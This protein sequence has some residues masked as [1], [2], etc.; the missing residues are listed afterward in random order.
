MGVVAVLWVEEGGEVDF[1]VV[2][3]GWFLKGRVAGCRDEEAW[4]VVA[5]VWVRTFSLLL[6]SLPL[7]QKFFPKSHFSFYRSLFI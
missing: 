4:V 6:I 2:V 5:A 3:V 1:R 7:I